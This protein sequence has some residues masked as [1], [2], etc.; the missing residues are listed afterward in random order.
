MADWVIKKINLYT[1]LL[2][3]NGTL[4][5]FNAV[6]CHVGL[7]S[8]VWT[9]TLKRVM[10]AKVASIMGTKLSPS[11]QKFCVRFWLHN[12]HSIT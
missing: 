8:K 10:I 6:L 9:F 3:D 2:C 7:V 5:I 1:F 11:Y 12:S 4:V